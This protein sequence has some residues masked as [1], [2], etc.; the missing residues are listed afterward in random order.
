[1]IDPLHMLRLK[2]GHID[3]NPPSYWKGLDLPT[4]AIPKDVQIFRRTSSTLKRKTSDP[5]WDLHHR[6]LLIF[7]ISGSGSLYVDSHALHLEAGHSLLILPFQS[8]GYTN[9]FPRGLVWIF[10]TFTLAQDVI[11][12]AENPPTIRPIGPKEANILSCLLTAWTAKPQ[13]A[14]AFLYAGILL[15]PFLQPHR[16]GQ[17]RPSTAGRHTELIAAVNRFVLPRLQDPIDGKMISQA[18][19]FSESHLRSLFR[20][21]AGIPLSTHVRHLRVQKACA[22]LLQSRGLRVGDIATECGFP[23]LYAFSRTFHV[24]MGCSPRRLRDRSFD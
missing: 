22:L 12:L 6:F 14:A 18:L 2:A 7:A 1:M 16:D 21:A 19:S 17:Q 24:V 8:H 15:F 23:S 9:I 3:I 13:D 10:V 4:V 5:R 20:E 11:L